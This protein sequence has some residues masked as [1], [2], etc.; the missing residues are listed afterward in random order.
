MCT[1]TI[2]TK[3]TWESYE[4]SFCIFFE[5]PRLNK[6][7]RGLGSVDE[8]SRECHWYGSAAGVPLCD[9][10]KCARLSFFSVP[11][12]NKGDVWSICLERAGVGHNFSLVV[13]AETQKLSSNFKSKGLVL[14]RNITLKLSSQLS[15]LSNVCLFFFLWLLLSMKANANLWPN[16]AELVLC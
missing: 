1:I 12:V 14:K 3:R 5:N 11:V 15:H 6:G 9:W 13:F 4:L 2:V 10:P 16:T 8:H 7:K